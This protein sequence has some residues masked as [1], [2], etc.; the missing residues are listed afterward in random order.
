[1]IRATVLVVFA[2]LLANYSA[3]SQILT[4][5]KLG[6]NYSTMHFD[7]KQ[8]SKDY[9]ILWRPGFSGGWVFNY[10][11]MNSLVWSFHGEVY[12][13]S[14]GRRI[15][16]RGLDYVK[17]VTMF[18]NI[19]VPALFRGTFDMGSLKWYVN[20]G[21]MLSYWMGGNGQISSSELDEGKVGSVRYTYDFTKYDAPRPEEREY[22][23]ANGIIEVPNANRLQVGLV[24][25]GGLEFPVLDDQI[26][27]LD[28]R[29]NMGHTNI[30][31]KEDN[32]F[33]LNNYF[34]DFEG[35]NRNIEISLAY[36]L[37]F[38][39]QARKRGKSTSTVK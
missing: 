12:Y 37:D 38:N 4:G 6:L 20:V 34:E 11:V 16:K 10:S 13:S 36:L 35:A 28:I 3:N 7:A 30:G 24:F 15:Q 26:V 8:Y 29:Y 19:D 32:F 25:G 18:H 33:G 2:L 39:V 1:M 31:E 14:K 17:N 5:P 9:E 21:P 22:P 23:I 27:Q